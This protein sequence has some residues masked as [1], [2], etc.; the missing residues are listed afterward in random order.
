MNNYMGNKKNNI[1]DILFGN[2]R[3]LYSGGNNTSL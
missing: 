1:Q 3:I 2:L